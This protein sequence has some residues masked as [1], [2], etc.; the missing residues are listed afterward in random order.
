MRS[1]WHPGCLNLLL[2]WVCGSQQSRNALVI[3]QEFGSSAPGAGKDRAR[4]YHRR[5]VAISFRYEHRQWWWADESIK[6]W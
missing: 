3:C 1:L 2:S 4:L 5:E 6:D